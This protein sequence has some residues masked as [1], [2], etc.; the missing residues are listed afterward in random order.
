MSLIS[1]SVAV[2]VTSKE[3]SNVPSETHAAEIVHFT[4]LPGEEA[5]LVAERDAMIAAVR[6][7][8]PG[9]VRAQLVNLGE[10]RWMDV[11]TW[12]SLADAHAAAADFPNIPSAAAWAAHIGRVDSMT[13]GSVEHETR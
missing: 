5:A 12:R 6:A 11:V 13:H 3:D 9:L 10:G 7:A 1:C 8:H 4:V 2:G